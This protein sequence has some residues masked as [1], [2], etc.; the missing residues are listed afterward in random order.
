MLIIKH[1][2]ELPLAK[3]VNELCM[4]FLKKKVSN[5]ESL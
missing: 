3:N 1:P 4:L 5:N 2:I